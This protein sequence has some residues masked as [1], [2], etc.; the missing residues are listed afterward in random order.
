MSESRALPVRC[1]QAPQ[2]PRSATKEVILRFTQNRQITNN[3]SPVRSIATQDSN[4]NMSLQSA[5]RLEPRL[6]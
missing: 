3:T 4:K 2:Q 6:G 1:N 5:L